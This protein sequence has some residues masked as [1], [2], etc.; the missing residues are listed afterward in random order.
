MQVWFDRRFG[1]C[2]T[3]SKWYRQW[4]RSSEDRIIIGYVSSLLKD[5]FPHIGEFQDTQRFKTLG[6]EIETKPYIQ[7]LN[8]RDNHW[9]TITTENLQNPDMSKVLVYDS[10]PRRTCQ[11]N[12]L[13][14]LPPSCVAENLSCVFC[15]QILLSNLTQMTVGSLQSHMLVQFAMWWIL[16]PIL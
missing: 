5:D 10:S 6:F 9:T 15:N 4:R 1:N 2:W 3:N 12:F 14:Q 16:A 13:K 11:L 8:V 7:I